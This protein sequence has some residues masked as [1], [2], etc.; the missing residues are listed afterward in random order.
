MKLP[1]IKSYCIDTNV[2]I[3]L[4]AHYPKKAPAFKAV[5]EEIERLIKEGN[6]YT[7]ELVE[8]EIKKYVGDD[9]LV[10]W[11]KA[12]KKQ[13]IVPVDSEIWTAGKKIMG[14]HPE[15]LDKKKLS[16]NEPE[17]DPFLIAL[18][19]S[20]GATIITQESKTNPNRIP[21]IAGYYQ[22]PC[23]DLFEFFNEQKLEF[24]KR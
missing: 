7:V 19:Y 2:L 10:K 20:K 23:I 6:M 8:A 3:T 12:H 16:D 13:F 17:A 24:V 18:A 5:W 11:I 4:K 15:L 14:E 1:F 22:I 21:T 9:F